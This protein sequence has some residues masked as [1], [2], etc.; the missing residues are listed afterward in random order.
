MRSAA[1]MP[2]P[3]FAELQ[4]LAAAGTDSS[5][6]AV[7]ARAALHPAAPRRRG[8]GRGAAG[9]GSRSLRPRPHFKREPV[10]L[11]HCRRWG[12]Q[13]LLEALPLIQEAVKRSRAQPELEGAF[14]ERLV[15]T[16]TSRFRDGSARGRS[17]TQ[18]RA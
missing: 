2:R 7:G 12:A 6:G 14:A 18:L 17:M 15:L 4:R 13:R 5:V 11:A 8:A 16:L 3:R 1:A 9:T 10:F